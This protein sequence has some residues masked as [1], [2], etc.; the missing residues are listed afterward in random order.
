MS[1]LLARSRKASC[2]HT[3]R[4]AGDEDFLPRAAMRTSARRGNGQDRDSERD[5]NGACYTG[6]P[7]AAGGGG[8]R[9]R[10]RGAS[11]DG[12]AARW[13]SAVAAALSARS[14]GD[15]WVSTGSFKA[16]VGLEG[17][18]ACFPHPFFCSFSPLEYANPANRPFP[19]LKSHG[20]S[21]GLKRYRRGKNRGKRP[22]AKSGEKLHM[23]H[24][25]EL[26]LRRWMAAGAGWP[27]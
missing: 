14:G 9:R 23:Q 26:M 19:R 17:R 27:F 4:I 22:Y 1:A 6:L 5:G 20:C 7:Q 25:S 12:R 3:G 21:G 10:G 24:C 16:L 8:K 13:G 18:T 2:S 11:A 15:G